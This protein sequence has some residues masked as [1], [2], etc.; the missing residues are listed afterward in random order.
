MTEKINK[1]AYVRNIKNN[2]LY[3]YLGNN[4]Y[5]NIRTNSE[6]EV[7]EEKAIEIFKINLSATVLISE[8]PMIEKLISKLGL[9]VD[10]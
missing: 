1:T 10:L 5:R 2:D 7:D 9:K 8:Y 6:G 4:K 3:E